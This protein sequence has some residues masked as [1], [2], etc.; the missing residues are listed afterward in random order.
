MKTPDPKSLTELNLS[1]D[2]VQV[3]NNLAWIYATTPDPRYRNPQRAVALIEMLRSCPTPPGPSMLD[4]AAASY[5][6]AGQFDQAVTLASQALK[7]A[8]DSKLDD[9]IGPLSER[10]RL[11]ETGKAYSTTGV[12]SE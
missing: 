6:A 4:T 5:A 9:E 11:Y 2:A 8:K 7:A 12:E 10:L 3:M 1:A